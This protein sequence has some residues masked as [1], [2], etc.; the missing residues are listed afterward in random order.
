MAKNADQKLKILYVKQLLEDESEEGRPVSIHRM[1]EYLDSKGIKA[2]RKSI[3]NDLRC[4]GDFGLEIINTKG[5]NGGYFLA[6]RLLELHELKILSDAVLSSRFLTK[7]KTKELIDKLALLTTKARRS[8]LKRR[9]HVMH[10]QKSSNEHIYYNIDG[11]Q[12]ALHSKKSISFHYTEWIL[13]KSGEHVSYQRQFRHDNKRYVA[14]P[15]EVIWDD[16]N[17]YF[18][19]K[20]PGETKNRTFRIDRMENITVLE[21]AEGEEEGKQ[22]AARFDPASYSAS[23]FDMYGGEEKPCRLHFH[24]SMLQVVL[25][26]FGEDIFIEETEEAGWYQTNQVIQV[27]NRFYGWLLGFDD[28]IRLAGP[29]EVVEDLGKFLKRV[30]T[31]YKIG[32]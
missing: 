16:E 5:A 26:R 15:I 11:I 6:S 3:Y 2:E 1:I 14:Y 29:K 25:D 30:S 27:S 18:L 21:D 32:E 17:Y 10:R 23:I 28:K 4:L 12:L 8:E 13:K 20:C 22:A 19:A 9:L 24:E 7:K 31:P